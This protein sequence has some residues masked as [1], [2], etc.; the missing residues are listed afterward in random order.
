MSLDSG[1]IGIKF[2][3]GEGWKPIEPADNH[4]EITRPE[5]GMEEVNKDT[6]LI[7]I[8]EQYLKTPAELERMIVIITNDADKAGPDGVINLSDIGQIMS[9]YSPEASMKVIFSAATNLRTGEAFCYRLRRNLDQIISAGTSPGETGEFNFSDLILLSEKWG[10]PLYGVR[11]G[12]DPNRFGH[13]CLALKNPVQENGTWKVLIY[14]PMANGERWLDLPNN[15]QQTH[16]AGASL[17]KNGFWS[18]SS[19]DLSIDGELEF[20][21]NFEIIKAKLA[22]FQHDAYNC[23]PLILYAAALRAAFQPGDNGFKQWG[24][25]ALEEATRITDTDGI[26]LPGIKIYTREEILSGK[27]WGQDRSEMD[28]NIEIS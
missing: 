17:W 10:I 7:V 21:N 4:I 16:L 25:F 5:I 12:E 2:P 20:A 8:S 19:Q 3:D 18:S 11:L 1:D 13:F 6:D 23:G 22:R 9:R 14:D 26:L 28:Q 24:R 15:W 27:E